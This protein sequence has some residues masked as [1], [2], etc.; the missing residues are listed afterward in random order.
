MLAGQ[1]C[2]DEHEVAVNTGNV[3]HHGS[4][5]WKSEIQV[6]AGWFFCG[7]SPRL[8]AGHLPSRVYLCLDL[9]L[10]IRTAVGLDE[11]SP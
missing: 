9:P 4:G 3:F 6:S 10:S 11:G 7:L 2:C 1:G 5:G 8:V